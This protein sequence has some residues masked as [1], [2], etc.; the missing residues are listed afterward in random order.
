MLC[1]LVKRKRPNISI[2][3]TIVSGDPINDA[4]APSDKSLRQH[5]LKVSQTRSPK[6]AVPGSTKSA[7]NNNLSARGMRR[8]ATRGPGLPASPIR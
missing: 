6:I 3:G 1:P 8:D 5:C 4:K 2:K 7:S